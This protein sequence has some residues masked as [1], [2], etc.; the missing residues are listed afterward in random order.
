MH[1]GVHVCIYNSALSS[2]RPPVGAPF[3]G[4]ENNHYEHSGVPMKLQC[5]HSD[6]PISVSYRDE[7]RFRS[8][9]VGSRNNPI[10]I[11]LPISEAEIN[12][13]NMIVHRNN[14][15]CYRRKKENIEQWALRCRP[16][17]T[18][19]LLIAA[20]VAHDDRCMGKLMRAW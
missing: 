1:V 2:V 12:R 14:H 16:P 9:Q 6:V 11:R 20:V 17:G 5:E 10:S 4:H 15:D 3:R 8:D 7:N 18:Q 13:K 19:L